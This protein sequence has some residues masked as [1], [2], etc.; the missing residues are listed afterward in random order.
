MSVDKKSALLDN[1]SVKDLLWLRAVKFSRYAAIYGTNMAALE[2]A[3]QLQ[4]FI[5]QNLN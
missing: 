5:L 3:Q 2:M 4:F 1:F